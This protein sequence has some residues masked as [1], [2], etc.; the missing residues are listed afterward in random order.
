MNKWG[1]YL[2]R[3]A[4]VL[5]ACV[6][7]TSMGMMYGTAKKTRA[8]EDSGRRHVS[9][10]EIMDFDADYDHASSHGEPIYKY[11]FTEGEGTMLMKLAAAE[12]GTEDVRSQL[13]V[14]LVVLNRR[15]SN[16]FPDSIEEI[17]F[18]KIDNIPQF[19][20]TKEGGLYWS[21]QPTETTEEALSKL[22]QGE[23]GSLGALYFHSSEIESCW[24]SRNAEFLYEYKGNRFYK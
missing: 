14:M 7:G 15:E 11:H 17:I 1:I 21:A 9:L 8:A 3:V 2:S 4:A 24:A 12:A 20:V 19:S 5:G 6:I 16:I 22:R 18:Q 13:L 23:N 10:F